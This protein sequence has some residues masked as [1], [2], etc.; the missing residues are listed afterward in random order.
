M[1]FHLL[2]AFNI[3]IDNPVLGVGHDGFLELAPRYAHQIDPRLLAHENAGEAL[4]QFEPHN[5]CL[6]VWSSFGTAALVL[7]AVLL[8]FTG[9]NFLQA[10]RLSDDPFVKG[11]AVG[12]LGTLVSFCIN[13][14]FHNF[15]TGT[16][17][18]WILAGLSLA[19]LQMANAHA[20]P[21][22]EEGS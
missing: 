8:L 3:A 10:A 6:N 21:P 13:S 16:L 2:T 18:V 12:G 4:G 17:T 5:H 11:I 7:Y 14:F 9:R 15:F 22:A 19:V 1:L 20:R